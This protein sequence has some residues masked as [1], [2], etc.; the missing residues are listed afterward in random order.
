MS[1]RVTYP[2]RLIEVDLPIKEISEYA[3]R[4]RLNAH[5]SLS[6]LHI[7]WARRPPAACR[8]VLA[9]AL[10]PDPCDP[11]CPLTFLQS[12][13]LLIGGLAEDA[14]SRRDIAELL[15]PRWQ[16]WKQ[17]RSARLGNT[18][19]EARKAL[20]AALLEF[21]VLYS[22]PKAAKNEIV[23][24]CARQLTSAAHAG[25]VVTWDPFAGGGTIPVEALRLCNNVI[26]SDLNPIAVMLNRVAVE[27]IPKFGSRLTSAFVDAARVITKQLTDQL[28]DLYPARD[29]GKP[30]VY[31]W[32][33]QIRCEGP[34]CGATIPLIRNLQVTRE[35]AR[36][37]DLEAANGEIQVRLHRDGQARQKPTVA[38]G[39]A[40]CPICH[41]TTKAAA[42]RLQLKAQHGGATNARLLAIYIDTPHGRTFVE[43]DEED[44]NGV[45]RAALLLDTKSLP[46][47]LINSVRPYDPRRRLDAA[48][49]AIGARAGHFRLAREGKLELHFRRDHRF[50]IRHLHLA[51][52][53]GARRIA[54]QAASVKLVPVR[55]SDCNGLG[56]GGWKWSRPEERHGRQGVAS[57][58]DLQV[59][60]ESLPQKVRQESLPQNR[61][62]LGVLRGESEAVSHDWEGGL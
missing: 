9:A 17:V 44:R 50:R 34:R 10:W 20:R 59:R 27:Y 4:E 46:N 31:L 48:S 60:Q 28:Q 62:V 49:H 1:S 43:P 24:N 13:A 38:G 37:H 36:R 52:V 2:K 61:G 55:L 53:S 57:F 23:M 19:A 33:R 22:D 8:A 3:R 16:K 11:K 58:E 41:F 12:G 30:I 35:G 18:D 15:A 45:S 39:S 42:I 26:A 40:T 51:D 56:R 7:W 25:A 21:I 47:D 5:G 29:S 6:T 14:Q 32:A 54:R